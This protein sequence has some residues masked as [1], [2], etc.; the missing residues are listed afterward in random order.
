MASG[1]NIRVFVRSFREQFGR[2]AASASSMAISSPIELR[3]LVAMIG[4]EA[5]L[6]ARCCSVH[7]DAAIALAAYVID[8][9]TIDGHPLRDVVTKEGWARFAATRGL[10]NTGWWRI[11]T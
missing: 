3:M 6:A 2:V 8:G 5:D 11:H 7:P 9:I 1:D 4:D 10:P